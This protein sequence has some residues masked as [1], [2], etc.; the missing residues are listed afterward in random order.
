MP[1]PADLLTVGDLARETGA[2]KHQVCYAIAEYRID[3]AQRAGIIRLFHRNQ[4]PM[5]RSALRR[6]AERR[7]VARA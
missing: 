6:I 7:E 1:E 4:L 5:I 2:K 3:P